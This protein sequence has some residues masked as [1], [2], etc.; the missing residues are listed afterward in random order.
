MMGRAGARPSTREFPI[1][2]TPYLL[3]YRVRED[4]LEVLA[5]LH[6]AR[7]RLRNQQ[8]PGD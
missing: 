7:N 8:S 4:N 6:G 2:G 5:L 3:I 1:P